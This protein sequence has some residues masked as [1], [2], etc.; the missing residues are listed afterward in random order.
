MKSVS[1]ERLADIASYVMP[2]TGVAPTD[3]GLVFGTRHGVDE[4]CNETAAL[5]RKGM[6]PLIV[7]SGGA[8]LGIARTE[9]A[10]MAGKLEDLGVPG[11]AI[12]LEH[13]ATNTG[14]NVIFSRAFLA[15]QGMLESISSVTAIGKIYSARRYLMTLERHWPGLRKHMAPVNFFGVCKDDWHSH[16]GFHDKV[17]AEFEKIPLYLQKGYLA[18]IA[19]LPSYPL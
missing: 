8:T 9:A 6:F 18:E 14:E 11:R 15:Q 16:E 7:V 4:F 12:L 3:I 13:Q 1:A 19:E 17:M 10:I 2:E 5:W